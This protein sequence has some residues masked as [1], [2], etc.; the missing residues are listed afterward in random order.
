LR[1]TI[2][3]QRNLIR[4]RGGLSNLII[5]VL[6]L[7]ILVVIVSNVILWSYQM[8]QLDWEKMQENINITDVARITR[9]SWFVT[10]S[11]YMVNRGSRTGGYYQDTQVVDSSYES[12]R[13]S[14]PSRELDVNGTFSIDLSTYPLAWIQS[15]EIQLRYRVDD[16]SEKWFLKAYNWTSKTYSNNSFNSTAGHTPALGWNLY[17]VNLTD[18]WRDYVQNNGKMLVK[19]HDELP[20]QPRKSI[21]IDFLGVRVAVNGALFTLQNKGS[22]TAHLVSIWINNS[23]THERY[24]IDIFVNS[25]ETFSYQRV[26]IPLP[27]GHYNVKLVT[28]RGNAAVYAAG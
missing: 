28:E 7:V 25:G 16:T 6:S 1:I 22:H 21:D 3:R 10:R 5:V 9:S 8:N 17:A 19:I 13:E 20:A 27:N 18:K 12:F 23:T 24:D 11:E 15:L 14:T 2:S 26:D 4:N